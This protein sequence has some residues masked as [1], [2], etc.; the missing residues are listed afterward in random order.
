MAIYDLD[1]YLRLSKLQKMVLDDR[2]RYTP[3]EV[4]SN[5]CSEIPLPGPTLTPP[6]P[7]PIQKY[8]RTIRTVIITPADD[9]VSPIYSEKAVIVTV[10]GEAGGPFILINTDRGD[11]CIGEVRLD[12]EELEEVVAVAKMLMNQDLLA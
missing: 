9:T 1:G 10:E 6:D 12:L 7:K 5:P 4:K 3:R 8:N 11:S 2:K